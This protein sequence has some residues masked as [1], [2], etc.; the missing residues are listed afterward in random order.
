GR[1]GVCDGLRRIRVGY[2]AEGCLLEDS[3]VPFRPEEQG[4]DVRQVAV[5]IGLRG[6][7]QDAP[8][9]EDDF[10]ERNRVAQT[11]ATGCAEPATPGVDRAARRGSDRVAGAAAERAALRLH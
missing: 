6:G 3:Q 1:E 5:R 10:Q 9:R 11:A 2:D 7:L 8:V 4:G